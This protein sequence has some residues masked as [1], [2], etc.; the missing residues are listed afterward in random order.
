MV[1]TIENCCFSGGASV[2]LPTLLL[3]HFAAR[4]N[5][6]AVAIP[7]MDQWKNDRDGGPILNEP[8]DELT[9]TTFGFTGGALYVCEMSNNAGYA[10]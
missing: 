1:A 10:C 2:Y 6:L 4:V 8:S 9:K 3:S 7:E 5:N